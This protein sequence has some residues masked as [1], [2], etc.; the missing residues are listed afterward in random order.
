M[1]DSANTQ[2]EFESYDDHSTVADD[3]TDHDARPPQEAWIMSPIFDMA[4]FIVTPLLIVPAVLL[5]R[6][7]YS[8]DEIYLFVVAFGATGHHL[9]GMLRAYGDS[10]LFRRYRTRFILAPIFLLIVCIGFAS[11]N[12]E[13]LIVLLLIWGFWHGMMQVY[14]FIRIYDAKAGSFSPV[15]AR[16]DW[17]MCLAW[18][19]MG[20]I[21]SPGRM[22]QIFREIYK[23]GFPLVDPELFHAFQLFWL[24]FTVFIS[25]VFVTNY[26]IRRNQG[27]QASPIKLLVMGT[28]FGFWWFCM[29]YV[30]H[31]LLG[32]ALFEIFHDVQYLAIVWVFNRKRAANDPEA[33]AFTRFLFRRNLTMIAVYL[34]L[35]FSYGFV[36]GMLPSLTVP[37][38]VFVT[39]IYGVVA[40][41]TFLHFYFDG[42]IWK[43]R[44]KSTRKSLGLDE[45]QGRTERKLNLG[46]GTLHIAKWGLFIVPA[47]LIATSELRS[48]G[49]KLESNENLVR[50][51]PGSWR[52][53]HD[54]G[55]ALTKAGQFEGAVDALKNAAEIYDDLAIAHADLGIAYRRVDD[56]DNAIKELNR[57]IEIDP[58]LG[59]AHNEIG[60]L[61][62][63]EAQTLFQAAVN[64]R[65]ESRLKEANEHFALAEDH[66]KRAVEL[67]PDD[68]AALLSLANFYRT[69]A[70][71]NAKSLHDKAEV[72][73][74]EMKQA[75]DVFDEL[76]EK[77][78]DFVDGM[79]LRGAAWQALGETDRAIADFDQAIELDP[80]QGRFYLDRG[81]LH[82]SKLNFE[83]ALADFEQATESNDVAISAYTELA[84]TCVQAPPPYQDLEEAERYALVVCQMRQL[85]D[86]LSWKMVADIRMAA[87][88]YDAA[89][90]ALEKS[91][92]YAAPDFEPILI[93]Q[94]R[95]IEQLKKQQSTNPPTQVP[96]RPGQ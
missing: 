30:P 22:V 57:A 41:S 62:Q 37:K 92:Q 18:F 96:L 61:E 28:S 42:F 2:D 21:W 87:K 91:M 33:G 36:V 70:G 25:L 52:A 34:V 60:K 77:H 81:K 95:L 66:L 75:I 63:R 47:A 26:L 76:I 24:G 5:A 23:A 6:S 67:L 13:G 82:R 78:P 43:V 72:N 38:E 10:A 20:L 3:V 73:V 53:W 59:I 50:L 85:Q 39:S 11:Q 71:M 17:F 90:L 68:Q 56:V 27:M 84:I 80:E 29:V 51:M 83:K 46:S 16:I 45:S 35:I 86:P 48:E 7:R 31:T 14:G 55:L 9:P 94:M 54:Y 1:S 32:I 19:G 15:T 49:L 69:H 8:I 74:E 64:Y 79:V 4:L 40:A 12:L 65:S 93:E 58:N 88:K 89:Q 44:E